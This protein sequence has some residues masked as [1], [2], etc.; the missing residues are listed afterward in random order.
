ML[1]QQFFVPAWLLL[2][3]LGAAT[4]SAVV[5]GAGGALLVLLVSALVVAAAAWVLAPSTERR[6]V[7]P[8]A[9]AGVAA[10]GTF[11]AILHLALVQAGRGGALFLDDAGYIAIGTAV[12]RVLAGENVT[13]PTPDPSL[14]NTYLTVVGALFAAVGPNVAAL[15]LLNVGM[16]SLAAVFAYRT[17]LLLAGERAARWTLLLLLVFPSLVLWSSLA[18]KDAFALL[19]LTGVVWSVVEF[20][21]SANWPW[22]LGVIGW[23]LPLQ[24]TRQYL[25]V[26][27]LVAWAPGLFASLWSR[28]HSLAIRGAA[29]ALAITVPLF[30][31]SGSAKLLSPETIASL[32]G[33]RRAMAVGARSAF[34]E[35]THVVV[36]EPGN[37]FVVEVPGATPNPNQLPRVHVVPLGTTLVY[38]ASEAGERSGGP[39]SVVAVRPGDVV[40]I[41]AALGASPPPA[42]ATEPMSPPS[43]T[44]P[45]PTRAEPASPLYVPRNRPTRVSAPEELLVGPRIARNIAHLPRGA[46]YMLGAPFPWELRTPTEL[47]TAPE[48]ALWYVTVALAVAGLVAAARA[49]RWEFAYVILVGGTIGAAL[50]LGEGNVG[51]L[52]RHRGMLV[53]FAVIL[54][55]LALTR[56]F[57]AFARYVSALAQAARRLIRA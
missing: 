34:V 14:V 26:I 39:S 55:S 36:G 1:H 47:A 32:E 30:L 15:K 6:F 10:R 21:K 9:L 53:P 49:R 45:P 18:L 52:V 13:I 41:T 8:V 20:V 3:L 54:A 25:F 46:V 37:A 16:A 44:S 42:A 2:A 19:C 43:G 31:L 4:A 22:F 24:S 17:S 48:L 57:P 5:S 40:I 38:D 27:L 33:I 29:A 7:V 12:A 56:P 28:S 50:S 11:A 51:T 35:P 23:S